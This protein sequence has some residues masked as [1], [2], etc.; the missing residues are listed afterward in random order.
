MDATRCPTEAWGKAESR[1]RAAQYTGVRLLAVPSLLETNSDH[2]RANGTM[3]SKNCSKTARSSQ[4]GSKLRM[5]YTTRTDG[6]IA[7]KSGKNRA[8]F[9][10]DN[11][12]FVCIP[13]IRRDIR[14]SV[15]LLRLPCVAERHASF[16]SY[17]ALAGH[18]GGKKP[19]IAR[20]TRASPSVRSSLACSV[21]GST[22][23]CFLSG[24][25]CVNRAP[26]M[27]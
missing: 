20:H 17:Q 12:H 6:T 15:P 10:F 11:T 7:R 3:K 19:P 26:C 4:T 24:V 2:E 13:H 22:L 14:Y 25:H 23:T 18:A 1:L 27:S 21:L 8:N 16:S 5:D 9:E